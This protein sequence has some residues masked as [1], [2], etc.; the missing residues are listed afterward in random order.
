M[1]TRR[2]YNLIF[3]FFLLASN[4]SKGALFGTKRIP[5]ISNFSY[6]FFFSEP[7]WF[8]VIDSFKFVSYFLDFLLFLFFFFFFGVF[9]FWSFFFFFFFSFFFFFIFLFFFLFVFL[10]IFFF[11]VV[12]VIVDFFFCGLF[13]PEFNRERNE[14]RVFFNKVF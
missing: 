3:V 7:N 4:K 13:Y 1:N 2:T 10:F 6:F 11:F 14:F 12:F 8:G 9:Y 5:L